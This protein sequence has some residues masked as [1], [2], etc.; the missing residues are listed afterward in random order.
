M[1]VR[2]C[3]ARGQGRLRH[4]GPD[5]RPLL[6]AGPGGGRVL[7]ARLREARSLR[8]EGGD[9]RPRP[10]GSSGDAVA[11]RGGRRLPWAGAG[12]RIGAAR[13]RREHRPEQAVPGSRDRARLA[14]GRRPALRQA[15]AGARGRDGG[16]RGPPDP[17]RGDGRR[18]GRRRRPPPGD[19]GDRRPQ[20]PR[21]RPQS[22]RG[23]HSEGRGARSDDRRVHLPGDSQPAARGSPPGAGRVPRVDRRHGL[24]GGAIAHRRAPQ[25][26]RR[27]HGHE[28]GRRGRSKGAAPRRE[29]RLLDRPAPRHR[30]PGGGGAAP[31][32]P[33]PAG[34]QGLPGDDRGLPGLEE[35]PGRPE[36][37]RAEALPRSEPPLHRRPGQEHARR[38][39]RARTRGAD[40]DR[41]HRR[42]DR[43]DPLSHRAA[44]GASGRGGTGATPSRTP[45]SPA[46]TRARGRAGRRPTR[47][48]RGSPGRRSG[49]RSAACR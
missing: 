49:R 21:P 5:R 47:G 28:A 42:L 33:D 25:A 41:G 43:Q 38:V 20:A 26:G 18:R 32:A 2:V 1:P 15:H 4:G 31:A 13:S 8:R 12:A 24:G 30:P 22:R 46:P 45:G 35:R 17:R 19:S 10:V 37:R 11:S 7:P 44:A 27:S 36:R 14:R 34:R 9:G 48:P 40:R 16:S 23:R 29:P 6:R 39:R 3:D